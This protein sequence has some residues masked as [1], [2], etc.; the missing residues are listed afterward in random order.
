MTSWLKFI[1]ISNWELVSIF[2]FLYP[3]HGSIPW[4]FFF[5]YPSFNWERSWQSNLRYYELHEINHVH[6]SSVA[7]QP[8]FSRSTKGSQ[9]LSGELESG[10]FLDGTRHLDS[11][12]S[13]RE[14]SQVTGLQ[15]SASGYE[16]TLMCCDYFLWLPDPSAIVD[17]L[18]P[19]RDQ[20][21]Q[22]HLSCF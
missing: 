1:L 13:P 2:S 8:V 12:S 4:V 15:H 5:P 16:K 7:V 10:R 17:K 14:H 21:G 18:T 22:L 19:Y 6:L 11:M 20:K 9:S 3:V